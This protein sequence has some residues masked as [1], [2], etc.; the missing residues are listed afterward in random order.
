MDGVKF[1]ILG[2]DITTGLAFLIGYD[3]ITGMRYATL[4]N[5]LSEKENAK[6]IPSRMRL[7]L[8]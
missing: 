2:K 4:V 1:A 5:S 8:P 3:G 7:G 6:L